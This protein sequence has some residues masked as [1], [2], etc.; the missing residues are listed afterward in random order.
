MAA[1]PLP[2]AP[3]EQI[4]VDGLRW[5]RTEIAKGGDLINGKG[6][7]AAFEE[8]C[9]AARSISAA[10]APPEGRRRL[11]RQVASA[12]DEPQFWSRS[13][14]LGNPERNRI[15]EQMPSKPG[16]RVLL[17][18]GEEVIFWFNVGPTADVAPAADRVFVTSARCPHQGVCLAD[19][20]LKEIEDLAGTKKAVV[21]CP[22]HNRLF[23]VATGQGEGNHETLQ[24]FKARFF[25]ELG[26]FYVAMGPAQAPIVASHGYSPVEV[27]GA[28][29]EAG[30]CDD[31]MDVDA[32][33]EPPMKRARPVPVVAL[34]SPAQ[35]RT[36]LPHSSLI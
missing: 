5:V 24:T 7:I 28:S 22:R 34:P 15:L 25:K 19:G 1:A 11:L 35:G 6:W 32:S 26:C 30:P 36:L 33:E 9:K 16:R 4:E 27:P 14:D 10:A 17:A 2:A 29:L 23:D 13:G 8:K 20:E 3:P 18:T 12:G 21:R 31:D